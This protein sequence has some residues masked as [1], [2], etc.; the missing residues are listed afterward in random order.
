MYA[1]GWSGLP[2]YETTS[3]KIAKSMGYNTGA[4]GKWHLGLNNK[5]VGDQEHGPLEHGFD[6]FYG[7][8]FTLV[9]E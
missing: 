7:L 1:A 3:A 2:Q 4:V 6:Y 9:D 8:P 5:I